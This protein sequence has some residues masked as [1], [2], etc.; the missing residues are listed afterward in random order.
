MNRVLNPW[1]RGG[2]AMVCLAVA[3]VAYHF[4]WFYRLRGVEVP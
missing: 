3:A 1:L 4:F 2:G